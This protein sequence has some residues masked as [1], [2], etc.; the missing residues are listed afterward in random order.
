MRLGVHLPLADLGDGLPSA[1]DLNDYVVAARDLGFTTVAANDHLVWSHP[2]LDG[3][4]ALASVAASAGDMTLATSI[5]LP[6]IRHPAV[7]AKT[8]TTLAALAR[9]PVV[10]GLGPGS[11]R[12]DYEAVG[13][14]FDERWTR[15]DEALP[16]V[17]ALV[18]GEPAESGRFYA[19]GYDITPRP[20]PPPGIW[21][22][23]WGSDRRLAAMAAAADGWF[24]SA[25]NATPDQYAEARGRL[26]A[27][28]RRRGQKPGLLPRCGRHRL[29]LRHRESPGG[30]ARS[31]GH[32]GA[33]AEAG[34][35]AAE[36]PADRQRAAL[37]RGTGRLRRCRR[38]RGPRVAGARL[39]PTARAVRIR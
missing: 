17:R 12:H 20:D 10:G 23:S 35:R 25:Y 30:R 15:F 34:P 39:A 19:G 28:L 5:T 8:L 38:G 21:F 16:L 26:D 3:T 14:P 36:A 31:R 29:A 27:H 6:V 13:I 4:A 18:R 22:A 32:P 7:V 33:D 24:A 2:W 11:S 37:L 9:G 1:V